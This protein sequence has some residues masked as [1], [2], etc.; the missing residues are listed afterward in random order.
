MV[1]VVFDASEPLSEQDV[2]IAGLVHEQQKPSVIIYNKW[3]LIEKDTN[4]INKFKDTLARDLAFMSYFKM[5]SVSALTGKRV[6][7]IM[8]AVDE[9]YANNHK[10]VKTSDLNDI[11]QDATLSTTPPSKAGKKLKIY[12]HL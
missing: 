2:R 1:I 5:E 11:I 6:E 10:R 12:Q 3:D 8:S 9:V 4:T 7:K